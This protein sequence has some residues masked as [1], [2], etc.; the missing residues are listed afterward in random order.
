ME[1]NKEIFPVTGQKKQETVP[2]GN[3]VTPI[4][5]VII[6][7]IGVNE[8]SGVMNKKKKC[9]AEKLSRGKLL[10]N[11]L[12]KKQTIFHICLGFTTNPV[13]A[14]E[15][16]QDIYLK[17]VAH[18]DSLK[19]HSLAFPWLLRITRNVCLNHCRR[20][21]LSR[22]IFK[23]EEKEPVNLFSPDI[24]LELKED[25]AALKAAIS[26]LPHKF[27]TVFILY[28]YGDLTYEEIASVLRIRKG[29]VMSRLSRARAKVR[30]TI[31]PLQKDMPHE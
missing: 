5:W 24:H 7:G 16:T 19:D 15:F 8:T 25:I 27:K 31:A 13:E 11:L 28:E 4:D 14:E 6:D 9:D 18:L 26:L 29:T 30:R 10:D 17:A 3:Y 22:N 21:R 1:Q 23:Q 12:E 2:C 20:E